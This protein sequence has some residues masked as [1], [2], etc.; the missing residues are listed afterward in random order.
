MV[1]THLGKRFLPHRDSNTPHSSMFLLLGECMRRH[2]GND[3]NGLLFHP[4][5]SLAY[6]YQVGPQSIAY[7]RRKSFFLTFFFNCEGK[8]L[9]G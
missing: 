1:E 8:L 6:F 2:Q 4:S 5:S 3:L 7:Q 9:V